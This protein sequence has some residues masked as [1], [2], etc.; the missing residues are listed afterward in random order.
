MG[1]E[2]IEELL[3]LR[4]QFLEPVEHGRPRI[5]RLPLG[6]GTPAVNGNLAAICWISCIYSG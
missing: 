6:P 4:H 2:E 3:F 1:L 5:P